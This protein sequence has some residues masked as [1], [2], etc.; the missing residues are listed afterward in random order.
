MGDGPVVKAVD[1]L[2]FVQSDDVHKDLLFFQI[3][4]ESEG[5]FFCN[6]TL[7]GILHEPGQ[8]G[9]IPSG[10]GCNFL[11]LLFSPIVG[12]RSE[13]PWKHLFKGLYMGYGFHF[14]LLY[15]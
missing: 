14:N 11:F 8:N 9:K 7:V 12:R 15:S 10:I 6:Q 3:H 4:T 2:G 5:R 13:A 1:L